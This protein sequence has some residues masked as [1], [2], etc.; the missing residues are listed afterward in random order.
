MTSRD[1]AR[2]SLWQDTTGSFDSSP[3][4][5]TGQFDVIIAGGGI[6]G[7]TLALLLQQA[8]KKCVVLEAHS[9]GYGTTGGT[10]AHLNTLLDNPYHAIIRDFGVDAAK[11]VARAATEAIALVRDNVARYSIDCG[12]SHCDGYLFAQTDKQVAQ[13]QDIYDSCREVGLGVAFTDV[14][15]IPIPFQKAMTVAGQARFHPLRYVMALAKAFTG[16]GGVIREGCRVLGTDSAEDRIVVETSA[17]EFRGDSVVFATHIPIGINMLHLRCPAYRSYVLAVK[18]E[19]GSYPSGLYYDLYDPYHYYR[20]QEIDGDQFLIIGGE[21]HK[22]GEEENTNGRFLHLESHIRSHFRVKEIVHRWSSQYFEPVDGLPYIGH[23]P[24]NHRNVYVATGYGGNGIT[25]SQ[26]AARVLHDMILQR[27]NALSGIFSPG[28]VKP[29]AGFAEFV[30]HNA[31]VVR[32]FV[33][34]GLSHAEMHELS[35]LS[36]GEAKVVKFN[37]ESIALYKDDE[38]NLHAISPLCTHMK[39]SVTWNAAEKSW[40][41]PCH[42]AR[43]SCDGQVLTGPAVRDLEPVELGLLIKET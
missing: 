20:T 24:G 32:R 42:G 21:D 30:K 9:L 1:G 4:V 41:C 33:G 18:L 31:D 39:C 10:T 12:F 14:L 2:R 26:V 11:Q 34:K 37:D 5:S 25:Y 27:T 36:E 22:T 19:D 38:G 7:V 3:D 28:R 15:D 29:V 6:T 35:A 17:G 43:Y 16:A 40:D 13:L 23:L 8:G